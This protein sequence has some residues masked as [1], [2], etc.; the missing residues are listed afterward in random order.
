[1]GSTPSG[2]ID[3]FDCSTAALGEILLCNSGPWG[4]GASAD[5]GSG[6]ALGFGFDRFRGP[7]KQRWV[8]RM[9]SQN[10]SISDILSQPL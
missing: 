9:R 5:A 2:L 6:S 10:L 7:I 4:K 1:M 3:G 8:R